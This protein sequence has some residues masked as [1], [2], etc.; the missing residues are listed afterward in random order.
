MELVKFIALKVFLYLLGLAC[1]GLC[2]HFF[3][4][5]V[6]GLIFLVIGLVVL[7]VARRLWF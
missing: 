2:I 5:Y 1:I 3:N 6:L 4:T 7:S